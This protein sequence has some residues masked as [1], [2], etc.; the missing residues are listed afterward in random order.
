MVATRVIIY[1]QVQGLP[2]DLASEETRSA[3]IYFVPLTG[4]TWV[5]CHPP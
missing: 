3:I 4:Q 5:L 1:G 2:G